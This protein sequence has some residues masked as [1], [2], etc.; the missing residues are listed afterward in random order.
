MAEITT[1]QIGN[2]TT[3][4]GAD[5]VVKDLD[6]DVSNRVKDDTPVLNMCMS[7]KR[8]VNST[9]PLW[10]DDIYRAPTV[11]AQ[12]EGAAVNTAQAQSN[13]RYN[14]GNYT[15]IFST[16][17][18]A[19]GTARAVMQAGGDPQAY[20]EVKQLI[21]L[22]FDVEMQLVRND[23]IG[24]KYAGQSGSASGLP[25]GQTGRRMGSLASFAG[26]QSYNPTSGTLAN[27]TT[28][29]NNESTDSST[30][31]V[32]AFNIAAQGSQFYTGTFTNQ[33]F[34]PALYKQLV[35]VAEQRYN[36]KIRTV[37]APTSL[38]TS[39]SDNMPQSR[40]INRVDSAR[41]DTIQTYEGDFN[42]TYEIFDSWIMD[43]VNAN[44]IFFLNEDVVQ[45]GSLRD[46]GPNNE[47]FSNSDASL[48]QF[49]MEGTLIVRNPAG[50]GML[51]NIE[52]GTSAQ[53]SLP[54]ARPAAYVQ[55][56]NQGAGDV[57]P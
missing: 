1:S 49:I 14:L 13:Q 46:L 57:T 43:T 22:M 35:T 26:T 52:A 45:W 53:A 55:R 37:V 27:I 11:Q 29:T 5:I 31:S 54:G 51:N 4:Y 30:A 33:Y 47:V 39:L 24:T 20:Q 7:K 38:R 2:G 25:S 17:I 56:V 28:N 16:V 44:A 18:A 6:L 3:A 19:S 40:G 12:V 50:V 41:G 9:L 36:A 42:Y 15:Q 21:E 10:T 8:K 32:G 48:D 34:S 23:Q